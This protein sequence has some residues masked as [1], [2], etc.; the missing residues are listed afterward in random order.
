MCNDIT[1]IKPELDAI[2]KIIVDTVP[3]ETIYLFGSYAYGTPGKD[4]DIDLY[5]VFKDDMQMRELDAIV[6]ARAA[7]YPAQKTPIDLLGEKKRQFLYRSTGFATVEKDVSK[8]GIKL[9]G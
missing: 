9:Y 6:A 2:T 5:I 4:S 1:S 3:V 8:K 7:M